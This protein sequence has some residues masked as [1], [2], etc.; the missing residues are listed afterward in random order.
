M[1]IKVFQNAMLKKDLVFKGRVQARHMG[2]G[3]I[4]I[5]GMLESQD[6]LR[7]IIDCVGEKRVKA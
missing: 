6:K 2:L 4:S 7:L 1:G 3:F 5:N